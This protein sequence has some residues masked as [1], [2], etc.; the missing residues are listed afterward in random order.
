MWSMTKI[1]NKWEIKI[2]IDR[3]QHH[4]NYD[5]LKLT[6]IETKL[7]KLRENGSLM[8]R[9]C[10]LKKWGFLNSKSKKGGKSGVKNW[11]SYNFT[12]DARASYEEQATVQSHPSFFRANFK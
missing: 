11:R 8:L 2:D 1:L 6:L 4:W 10:M 3:W 5:E 9:I 7:L 12:K